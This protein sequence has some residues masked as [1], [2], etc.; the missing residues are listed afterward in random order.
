MVVENLK[1]RNILSGQLT[2]TLKFR[3]ILARKLYLVIMPVY[4]KTLTFDE[5]YTA[6]INDSQNTNDNDQLESM[7]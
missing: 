3:E 7:Q 6:E 4:K 1:R 5:F 2:V